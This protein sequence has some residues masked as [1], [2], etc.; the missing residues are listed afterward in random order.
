MLMIDYKELEVQESDDPDL[1]SNK[2]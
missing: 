1:S 2:K